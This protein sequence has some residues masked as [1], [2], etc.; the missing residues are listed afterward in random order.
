[1]GNV[2]KRKF[3]S[4]NRLRGLDKGAE[5]GESTYITSMWKNYD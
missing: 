5:E 1:M 3:T 4:W 2:W